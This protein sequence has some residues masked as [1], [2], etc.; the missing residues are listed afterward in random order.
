MPDGKFP[1]EDWLRKR[2]RWGGREGPAYNTL[3]VYIQQWVG[4]IRKLRE[5]L[6]QAELST[7]QWDRDTAIAAYK[8]FHA[9]HGMTPHQI[10]HLRKRSGEEAPPAALIFEAANLAHAISK[11]VGEIAIVNEGLGI[12]V[13]KNSKWS[14]EKIRA[15]VKDIVNKYG[16]TPQQVKSDSRTGK[17]YLDEAT[18]KQVRTVINAMSRYP[19]GIKAIYSDLGIE[20]PRR[21]MGRPPGV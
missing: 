8:A 20:P 5:L 4:G 13:V 7:R 19:G 11:Y 21:K 17:I 18:T 15:A 10:R 9:K 16:S 2:G 1:A 3:A 6:G 12:K 14:P